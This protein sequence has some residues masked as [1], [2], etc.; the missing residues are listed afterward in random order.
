[1]SVC[2]TVL[3]DGTS[4]V[5]PESWTA[6][7]HEAGFDLDLGHLSVVKEHQESKW[8]YRQGSQFTTE[9][10]EASVDSDLA[11]SWLCLTFF[12][13]LLSLAELQEQGLTG[14]AGG[15][16]LY[17]Y[18]PDDC[19]SW[20]EPPLP[21]NIEVDELFPESREA[22]RLRRELLEAHRRLFEELYRHSSL[23]KREEGAS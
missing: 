10:I 15:W 3:F 20:P 11:Q 18:Y 16:Y 23:V 1:M 12:G 22:A 19:Y 7:A 2:T 9:L 5:S 14:N 8:F 4:S 17:Q 6:S 13:S 21:Q